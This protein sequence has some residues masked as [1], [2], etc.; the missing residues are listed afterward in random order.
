MQ[1]ASLIAQPRQDCNYIIA[2]FGA[3]AQALAI[4]IA[5]VYETISELQIGSD[6]RVLHFEWCLTNV[7]N[8][9]PWKFSAQAVN[10]ERVFRHA[11]RHR[12][13]R[14]TLQLNL[15]ERSIGRL[16]E[17]IDPSINHFR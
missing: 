13:V 8:D 3:L 10:R 5:D 16:T 9:L 17:Q 6:Q 7:Q 1:R 2:L 15:D 11:Q 14:T 12:V 4:Q